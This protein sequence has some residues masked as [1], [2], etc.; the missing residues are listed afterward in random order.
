MFRRAYPPVRYA[1]FWVILKTLRDPIMNTKLYVSNL[2]FDTTESTVAQVFACW[3]EVSE[4]RLVLDRDTGR[5]RVAVVTLLAA[6]EAA[7][8]LA[9][10]AVTA[11]SEA[12]T[13]IPT[14]EALAAVIW[15]AAAYGPNGQFADNGELAAEWAA[16]W[17]PDHATA[18]VVQDEAV[19][20]VKAARTALEVVETAARRSQKETY[21][22][23]VNAARETLNVAH[24]A[25]DAAWAVAQKAEAAKWDELWPNKP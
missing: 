19:R 18:L 2:S 25:L 23:A 16:A 7:Y 14:A 8:D 15:L 22:A 12:G 1:R 21:W 24:A 9:A 4:V 13:Y 3:G 5:P 17:A 10:K 6:S 11:A 20:V